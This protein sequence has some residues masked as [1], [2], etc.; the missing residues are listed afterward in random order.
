VIVMDDRA[1]YELEDEPLAARQAEFLAAL[2]RRLG[3]SLRPY[4]GELSEDTLLLVLDVDA[5]DVALVSVG[6]LVRGDELQGDRISI[7]HLNF[8]PAPT[9]DGFT[10]RGSPGELA[11]RGGA[12]F[13]YFASRPVVRHEW[14]HR[15]KVYATCY[16]FEDSGERLS[17]MYRSDWAP[18]GQE[19]RLV[20]EGFVHGR[21]WIQTRGLGDPQRVV[22]V[23]G[24]Q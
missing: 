20:A 17:Q 9:R 13:E 5:P 2:R 8:P 23:R 24:S 6:L 16:L 18:R 12:L 19:T 14:L 7:H 22:R 15:G 11:D 1:F 4:C 10:V 21:G 3:D